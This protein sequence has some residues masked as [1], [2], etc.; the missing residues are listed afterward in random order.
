[1]QKIQIFYS[2]NNKQLSLFYAINFSSIISQSRKE[3]IL[4]IGN[5]KIPKNW[6]LKSKAKIKLNV[7]NRLVEL[8]KISSN[9]YFLQQDERL[10]NEQFAFF[11][12]ELINAEHQFSYI[13]IDYS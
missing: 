13:V 2:S 8:Q 9:F 5:Q 1:M 11:L 4:F 12:E 10:S 6:L 3:N 7:V